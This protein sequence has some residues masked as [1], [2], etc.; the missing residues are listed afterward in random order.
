MAKYMIETISVFRISYVVECENE[1]AA[2]MEVS[3]RMDVGN[4][5][6]FSQEHLREFICSSREI[7]KEEYLKTF[8][9]ANS[10]L[11]HLNDDEKLKF[12]NTVEQ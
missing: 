1:M 12:I 5:K 7:T 11:F 2:R 10:Y 6:E 9:E 4:L 8:S 3:A